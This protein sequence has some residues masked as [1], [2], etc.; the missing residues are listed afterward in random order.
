MF[1]CECIPVFVSVFLD[2][3]FGEKAYDYFSLLFLFT[4]LLGWILDG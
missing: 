4:M 3:T 1:L 2:D